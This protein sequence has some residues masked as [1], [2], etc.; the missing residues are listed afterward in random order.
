MG[1]YTCSLPQMAQGKWLEVSGGITCRDERK[2]LG[3]VTSIVPCNFPFMVPMWTTPIAL[4]MGNCVLLKP[5]EKVP[6]TMRRVCDLM[7]QAGF[8][9]GV[10]NTINGTAPVVNAL[11]DSPRV[12]AVTFVGSSAVA[13]II[14]TKCHAVHKRVLA[15]GGAK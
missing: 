1:E 2:P 7:V 6:F 8:P 12:S 4:V 10:F 5:S 13:Q 14:A 11:I 3:V 15:L 9:R